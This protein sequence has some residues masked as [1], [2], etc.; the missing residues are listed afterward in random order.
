MVFA[1]VST[2]HLFGNPLCLEYEDLLGRPI[3]TADTTHAEHWEV[4]HESLSGIRAM[5]F[6]IVWMEAESAG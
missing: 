5:G 1:E 3:W 6:D 4:S 2:E